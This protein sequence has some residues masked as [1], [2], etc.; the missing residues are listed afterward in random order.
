MQSSTARFARFANIAAWLIAFA[1][2]SSIGCFVAMMIGTVA[3][4]GANDG[5]SQGWWPWVI[6]WPLLALPAGFVLLIAIFVTGAIDR[7]RSARAE[8]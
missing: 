1:V 8:R 2:V 7:R 6:S 5:F 3:G 4:V